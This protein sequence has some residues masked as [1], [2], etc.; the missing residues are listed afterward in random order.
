MRNN[1]IKMT[2]ERVKISDENIKFLKRMKEKGVSKSALV[3]LALSMLMPRLTSIGTTEES[4]I[5]AIFEKKF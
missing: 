2:T 4:I 3:N 5:K 1:G